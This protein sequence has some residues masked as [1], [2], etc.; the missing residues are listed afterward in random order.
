MITTEIQVKGEIFN[1]EVKNIIKE[2]L[3]KQVDIG[4]NLVFAEIMSRAPHG[5]S[6]AYMTGMS[7]SPA[8]I[9]SDGIEGKILM[10]GRAQEYWK[11][12]EEGRYAGVGVPTGQLITWLMVT[13]GYDYEEAKK[14]Q[15]GL[16][17]KI[18]IQG[19]KGKHIV[20]LAAAFIRPTI[21]QLILDLG[22]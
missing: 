10:E 15:F 14:K 7:V 21:E 9:T 2:H 20:A 11:N 3:R 6:A 4:V 8:E 19:I 1:P 18:Y 13:F 12:V 17:M 22:V 5:A 16:M